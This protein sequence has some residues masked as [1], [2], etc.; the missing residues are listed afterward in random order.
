MKRVILLAD[1]SPTIQRFVTQIFQDSAYEV[2][3]VSNG[4]AAIRKFEEI[5]P[6]LVL[7]DIYMPG[8]NGY[9]VCAHIKKHPQFGQTPVVLLAGAFD[10]FDE[11]TAYHAGAAT[12]VTKPFEPH[13]LV[14]LVD[15][16]LSGEKPVQ[17]TE[18]APRRAEPVPPAEAPAPPAPPVETPPI[19]PPASVAAA[20][21]VA[22]VPAEAAAPPETRDSASE[23]PPVVNS[24]NEAPPSADVPLP[25]PPAVVTEGSGDILGLEQL[26][27][28]SAE[29]TPSG[30]TITDEEI[31]RIAERV[32]QKISAQVIES[33]AWDV[34]PDITTRVLRE[35]LKRQS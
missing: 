1:D 2:I 11:E 20:A 21:T 9:E 13:A 24:P 33:I 25:S 23:P 19:P 14:G 4:D 26:F 6:A 30:M 17:E 18:S 5:H 8:R 28:P 27:Q 3:S 35:E 10:A 32:L 12:H 15:S 34:V 7:A 22:S 29:P 31:D 16:L